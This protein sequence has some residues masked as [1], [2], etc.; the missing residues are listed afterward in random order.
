MIGLAGA[1]ILYQTQTI[2]RHFPANAYVAGAVQLFGSI[3]T[4]FYYVLRIFIS[5]D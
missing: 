4:M 1:A 3:M 2:I 5:R